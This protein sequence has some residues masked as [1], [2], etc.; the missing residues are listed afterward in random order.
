[1]VIAAPAAKGSSAPPRLTELDGLKGVSTTI[2]LLAHIEF[3]PLF[4]SWTMMDMFFVMSSF[5]LTGIVVRKCRDWRGVVAFY[6]RR[7]ERIWPM[8]LI[9]I[10]A[11]FL[12][13]L[14]VNL[15][16]G[17]AMYD[18]TGF[19][20]LFTFSQFSELMFHPVPYENYIALARHTWSLAIEEQFYVLLPLGVLLLRA[21]PAWIG[22]LVLA[23]VILFS[24]FRRLAEPNMYVLT[25]HL[26]A[27]ALGSLLAFALQRVE[28]HAARQRKTRW[29]LLAL[30]AVGLALLLPYVVEGY[31]RLLRGDPI[32]RYA[33]WPATFSTLFWVGLIGAL[34]L[35]PGARSLALLRWGPLVTFGVASY[36]VYLVHYPI[37][38]LVPGIL[39]GWLP[40]LGATA[41]ELL[42]LPLVAA[43]AAPLYIV[44]DLPL[45]RRRG[46]VLWRL[47]R[48]RTSPAQQAGAP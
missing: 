4:W 37:L 29:A 5:L 24:F 11:L 15:R 20:R 42:C 33:G 43:V 41:A 14:A 27:F 19:A 38:R 1:M 48:S 22:A 2:V 31:A 45:Q 9:V 18:L 10:S 23:A 13:C 16:A 21:W 17:S 39:Q 46:I 6:G 30:A 28:G 35:S 47:W 12:Y 34:A 32:L 25:S 7:I 8:Y 36:V 3:A 44:I 40:G 26:D